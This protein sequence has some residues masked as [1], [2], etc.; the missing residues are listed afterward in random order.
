MSTLPHL[1]H[2]LQTVLTSVADAAAVTSGFVQRRSKV[3]GALFAQTLVFG[4]LANA[5]ATLED[6]AQTA[7]TRGLAITPQGLEQRFT[8]RAAACLHQVLQATMRHLLGTTPVAIPL[9]QRFAGVYVRDSST[10]G[11]PNMLNQVW[12]G[13][14]GSTAATAQAALKVHVRLDLASGVIDGLDLQAGRAHDSTTLLQMAPLPP[15]ALRLADLGYFDLDVLTALNTD[16]TFWL[17]RLHNRT[18]V[19]NDR[20]DRIDVLALLHT[21]DLDTVDLPVFV[22]ATHRLPAR[23]LAARVPQEVADQR[24]RRLRR[25][26]RDTGQMVTQRT[27]TLAAW[28]LLLTNVPAAMLTVAEA[29]VLV[30]VRW[31]IELLFKLWKSH[32]RIDESRSAKPWRVLCEVYAKLLARVIQHWVLLTRCWQY[33][34]RSLPKAAQTI[35]KHALHLASTLDDALSLQHAVAVIQRCLAWGCRIN[36]RKQVPHTYQRLLALADPGLA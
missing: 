10:I 5:Q 4:W 20:D 22:G 7:A 29:L 18:T 12:P 9:F 21:V 24:R 8:A 14:G 17:S 13:C 19:C 26:A 3:T 6:L 25:D 16:G 11:L 32:G 2:A 15:G 28:T 23:L 1:V 35:Q 27:L 30:R 34:D 33:P 36:K 31:Q